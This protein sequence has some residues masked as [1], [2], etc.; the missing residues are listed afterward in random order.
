MVSME[1][2]ETEWSLKWMNVY[3]LGLPCVSRTT[4]P[5]L[6]GTATALLGYRVQMLTVYTENVHHCSSHSLLSKMFMAWR[7][8]PYNFTNCT[9]PLF[10]QLCANSRL[11]CLTVYSRHA[12]LPGGTASP[13]ENLNYRIPASLNVPIILQSLTAPELC[14]RNC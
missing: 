12:K 13:Y 3:C 9:E 1:T 5:V 11:T 7:L 2:L 10:I 14:S 4:M 6:H 8:I